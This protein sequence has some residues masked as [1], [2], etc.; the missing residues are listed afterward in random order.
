MSDF[1]LWQRKIA[2]WLHDL[3]DKVLDVQGHP[4]K[5]KEAVRRVTKL[6][7]AD[8]SSLQEIVKPSDHIAS[9]ADRECIDRPASGYRPVVQFDGWVYHPLSGEPY[10][11]VDDVNGFA[12]AAP[13][14]TDV[15]DDLL[16]RAREEAKTAYWVLW[17]LMQERLAARDAS[18]DYLPATTRMPDIPIWAHMDAASA[19]EGAL[20]RPAHLIFQIG[21]VQQFIAPSR[22]SQDFWMGSYLISFLAWHAMRPIVTKLGPD[23]I[24]YPD[25]RGQPLLDADPELG[26]H[27]TDRLSTD[28]RL[29]SIASLPHRFVALVPTED[30]EDLAH[31]C[32]DAVDNTWEAAA[33]DVA[34]SLHRW[35]GSM[36]SP[37]QQWEEQISGFWRTYYAI[38]PWPEPP[39][40]GGLEWARL[41]KAEYDGLFPDP[42]DDQ[43]DEA[44]KFFTGDRARSSQVQI[45]TA[46]SRLYGLADRFSESVKAT[47]HFE[48]ADQEGELCTCCGQRSVLGSG[49]TASRPQVRKLWGSIAESLQSQGRHREVKPDGKER[50]CAVCAVKRFAQ[51][52]S[53]VVDACID[54]EERFPSTST[55]AAAD[56]VTELIATATEIA[57]GPE[58]QGHP[59]LE[60]LAAFVAKLD[61]SA[62]PDTAK[63][64]RLRRHKMAI[65]AIGDDGL[66]RSLHTL[67]NYDGDV[68]FPHFFV[69]ERHL[70]DFGAQANAWLGDLP[71]FRQAQAT[72]L[73]AA[74][75]ANIRAPGR[76]FAVLAFDGD[77]VGK[78]LSGTNAPELQDIIAEEIVGQDW[79]AGEW[80]EVLDHRRLVCPSFHKAI[81]AALRDFALHLA[82][83]IVEEQ[84]PG[85]L[86]YAGGDDLL[87]LVPAR[88]ALDLAHALRFA[89]TGQG[90]WSDGTWIPDPDRADGFVRKAG[91]RILCLM[92]SEASAS[93]G[94]A[95]VHHSSPLIRAIRTAQ[96]ECKTAAKED[97]GRNAVA[98]SVLKRGGAPV[99]AGGH[100]VCDDTHLVPAISKAIDLFE[101]QH[102]GSLS[103]GLPSRLQSEAQLIIGLTPEAQEAEFTRVLDRQIALP[104][105]RRGATKEEKTQLA[106]LQQKKTDL[107][108]TC[109]SLMRAWRKQPGQSQLVP[110][111]AGLAR[112]AA[113][114]EELVNWLLIARFLT[115]GG[116]E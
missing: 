33:S 40:G 6:D 48:R 76:Y 14:M 29:R 69:K 46:Y 102:V 91:R 5:A 22:R 68:F 45:G 44:F 55:I 112:P 72:L 60:A 34:R 67:L 63:H 32:Q 90:H 116:E 103:R 9:A 21:P 108:D 77:E 87:A 59:L 54:G 17:R 35:S 92:G 81:S 10:K 4:A 79:F 65:E 37:D 2:A 82:P 12:Q 70:N 96:S 110:G 111:D 83:Q 66:R 56:F 78:W 86:V 97:Y 58:P 13:A 73:E 99:R 114:Y 100:F 64:S 57:D 61:A 52:E 25:L 75:S 28:R 43:F 106:R 95:V 74:T 89:F 26:Q 3:P 11:V 23:A 24:L 47:R 104:R 30:A 27:W 115:V 88:R 80:D 84:Y 93:V 20:P 8:V 49:P 41:A 98:I 38:H 50:L 51:S 94:I 107:R 36:W 42:S 101:D 16:G 85:K 39:D 31:E 1:S 53:Q 15:I 18:W 113:P 7:N 62:F 19:V 109:L 105:P 71:G